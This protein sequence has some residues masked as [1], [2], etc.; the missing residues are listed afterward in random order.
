MWKYTLAQKNYHTTPIR[1]EYY[2]NFLKTGKISVYTVII[3][4]SQY[5]FL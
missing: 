2:Y 5:A 3:F 1:I 4:I